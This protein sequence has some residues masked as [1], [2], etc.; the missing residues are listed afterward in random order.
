[1]FF[2]QEEVGLHVN[3]TH[4]LILYQTADCRTAACT[5]SLSSHAVVESLV[6]DVV[7][8]GD[9]GKFE[10]EVLLV[11]NGALTSTT[12]LWESSRRTVWCYSSWCYYA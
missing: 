3:L 6:E 7:P 10:L 1:M 2:F 9:I 11:L 8:R 4:I 12:D 5:T